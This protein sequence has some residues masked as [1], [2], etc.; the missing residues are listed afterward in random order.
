MTNQKNN[1]KQLPAAHPD[2]IGKMPPQSVD[3]EN[4]VLGAMLLEKE[5]VLAVNSI[6]KPDSFYREQNGRVFNAILSLFKRSEPVDILT[7]TQELRRTGELDLVGGAYYVSS[8]T[9]RLAS[10]ANVEYHARIVSQK[11]ILRELIRISGQMIRHAYEDTADC[12][13]IIDEYN[14]EVSELTNFVKTNVQHVGDVFAEVI[15]EIAEVQDKGLPTGVLSGF[16]NIDKVT[17]GWQKGTLNVLAARPGMGKTALALA[18]AKY[19]AMEHNK[20]TMIFSLEMTA[21]QL[22]GRLASS[23]SHISSSKINQKSISKPEL[24]GLGERCYK[25][26][27][28]PIYIDDTPNI[29]FSQLKSVAKK[30]AADKKIELIII[31]YLQLMGGEEKGNREQEI[32]Y[33]SRNLKALSKEL[34]LPV[35]ALSQL[36]RRVEERHGVDAK[37]PQLSDLRESGAIEQDADIVG[38]LFRPEYYDMFPDGYAYGEQTLETENL[39]LV[40]FAKGREIRICE[41]PLKFYGE[42]MKIKNYPLVRETPAMSGLE[43]NNE[44]LNT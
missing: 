12:F 31:D 3:L 11:H 36:S 21:K 39:M 14:K 4:A 15:T 33:I 18:M 42:F 17:G 6:L 26:I 37:R 28:S 29:K 8:L 23:E 27:D 22:T 41:V 7:V 32:S 20:P 34:D 10:S 24:Q 19:P 5:A 25:L 1:R 2:Q 35:I 40:D 13:E 9:E 43:N 16:E 38:F 30:M 44:F